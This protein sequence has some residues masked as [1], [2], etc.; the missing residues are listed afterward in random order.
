M[1]AYFQPMS[2]CSA[3]RMR[4]TSAFGAGGVAQHGQHLGIGELISPSLDA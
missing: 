4:W 1:L 2:H 3:A